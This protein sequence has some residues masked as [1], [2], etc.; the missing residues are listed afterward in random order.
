MVD[1]INEGQIILS[2]NEAVEHLCMFLRI[3]SGI[4]PMFFRLQ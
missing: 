3:P 1:D 4:F 2:T